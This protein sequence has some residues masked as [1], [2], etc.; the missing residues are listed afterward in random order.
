MLKLIYLK[1]TNW[2]LSLDSRP[3]YQHSTS[4][5]T[6]N[7]IFRIYLPQ[8]LPQINPIFRGAPFL[9]MMV[10]SVRIHFLSNRF[11]VKLY[12]CLPR[13]SLMSF[14]L[15]TF[16][17]G[18][19]RYFDEYTLTFTFKCPTFF[20]EKH[21]YFLRILYGSERFIRPIF[22]PLS[23]LSWEEMLKFQDSFS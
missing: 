13:S 12:V 17:S 19:Y 16:L 11:F 9:V 6:P 7:S 8:T 3:S 22:A 23:D 5:A 14:L 20:N 10:S 1:S 15:G 18:Q 4:K 2:Y 21:L